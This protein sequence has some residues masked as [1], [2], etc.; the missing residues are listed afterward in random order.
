M[1][2]SCAIYVRRERP[3]CL[4]VV[5][6]GCRWCA[7]AVCAVRRSCTPDDGLQAARVSLVV[8]LASS[9]LVSPFVL[10]PLQQPACLTMQ[11]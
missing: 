3:A 11:V 2:Q 5:G 6:N 7:A 1:V 10:L 4:G 8:V 9:V